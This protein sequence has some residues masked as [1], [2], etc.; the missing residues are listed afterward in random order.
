M[1][2]FVS[3]ARTPRWIGSGTAGAGPCLLIFLESTDSFTV[4]EIIFYGL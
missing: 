2:N 4:V 1:E 3:H